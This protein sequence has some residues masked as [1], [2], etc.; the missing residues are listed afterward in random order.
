M[1]CRHCAAE[2]TL[3]LIDLG[4]A[5]PSN[6]YLTRETLQAPE[7]TY[8]LRVVVCERCWLVQTED[9][10]QADELF[11]SEYAYFS[12][13]STSW[14]AHAERYVADMSERFALGPGSHVVEVAS[15]DGYLLQYVRARGIPCLG[16]EP[17]A[18][19]AKAARDKGIE[20][21]ESFFGARVG[22]ELAAQGRGADRLAANN[23]LAHVP[24]INVF[25]SGVAR[26]L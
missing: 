24:V 7:K 5:P 4:S 9:F 3:Q 2:L 1:K 6:A 10:A 26:L 25:V 21:L 17:T 23:V 19:T 8:P 20:T 15:N 14:L 22:S 11:S 18:S 16:V 12:G 13:F